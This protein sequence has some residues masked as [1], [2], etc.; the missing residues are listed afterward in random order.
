MRSWQYHV[1]NAKTTLPDCLN[2]L[3]GLEG[4][5]TIHSHTPT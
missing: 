4:P 2:I 1:R 5:D 3:R